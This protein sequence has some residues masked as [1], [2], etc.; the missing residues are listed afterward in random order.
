MKTSVLQKFRLQHENNILDKEKQYATKGGTV[1]VFCQIY[2]QYK[3]SQGEPVDPE[4]LAIA[5]EWDQSLSE[6]LAY[7]GAS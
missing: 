2:I 6:F 5:M 3:E 1:N 7:I 4:V